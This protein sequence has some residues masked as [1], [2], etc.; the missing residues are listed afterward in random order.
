MR[1]PRRRS[2]LVGRLIG[3]GHD[4]QRARHSQHRCHGVALGC[5]CRAGH[6]DQRLIRSRLSGQAQRF[7][8]RCVDDRES[9]RV[10]E[11]VLAIA[12]RP[13][14]FRRSGDPGGGDRMPGGAVEDLESAAHLQR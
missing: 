6:F 9:V 13:Q 1:E 2:R 3:Q 14:V 11:H 5:R 7:G 12:G 10:A 8:L 4:I